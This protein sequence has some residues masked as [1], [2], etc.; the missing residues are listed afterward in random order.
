MLCTPTLGGIPYR[1]L[2]VHAKTSW[3]VWNKEVVVWR[4]SWCS[5]NQAAKSIGWESSSVPRLNS[6]TEV[7]SSG[8]GVAFEQAE[9]EE[10]AEGPHAG[11]LAMVKEP[12]M[13]SFQILRCSSVSIGSSSVGGVEE[14]CLWQSILGGR[15]SFITFFPRWLSIVGSP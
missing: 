12:Y 7:G 11:L 8:L 5:H 6:Q 1:S 10:I 13:S 14:G 2:Y 9:I 3:N 15:W 4:R